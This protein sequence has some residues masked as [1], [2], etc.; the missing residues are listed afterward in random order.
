L[1]WDMKVTAGARFNASHRLASKDRFANLSLAFYSAILLSISII[2]VA[3]TLDPFTAKALSVGGIVA[4]VMMLI[5]SMKMFADR[6]AVDSEQMHRCALE[7]NEIRRLYQ[8]EDIE[9]STILKRATSEYNS[10]LQKYSVNHLEKD[11]LKYKF[12]HRWEFDDLSE[13]RSFGEIFEVVAREL[14]Q[15]V[16]ERISALA[17]AAGLAA[18]ASA[19][20]ASMIG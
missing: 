3:Y 14:G 11:Y 20:I 19:L 6:H 15:N 4:S 7:I 9:K 17:G 12:A 10:V 8:S 18:A 1:L 2:T 5:L 16:F 13:S